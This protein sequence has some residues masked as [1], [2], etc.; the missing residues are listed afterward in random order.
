MINTKASAVSGPT[1]GWVIIHLMGSAEWTDYRFRG[2]SR[3][4][5]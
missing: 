5:P 4:G 3:S 2:M 1:P